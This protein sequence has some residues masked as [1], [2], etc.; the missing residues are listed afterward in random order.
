MWDVL[1]GMSPS[2][3]PYGFF[4]RE[5]SLEPPRIDLGIEWEADTSKMRTRGTDLWLADHVGRPTEK[6][7]QTTSPLVWKLLGWPSCR[8]LVSGLLLSRFASSGRPI[9]PRERA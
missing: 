9:D 5:L 4:C 1:Y 8:F 2:E 6:G 3:P 7:G